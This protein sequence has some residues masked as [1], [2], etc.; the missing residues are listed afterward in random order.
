MEMLYAFTDESGA[1]GWDFDKKGVSTHFIITAIIIEKSKLD[2]LKNELEKIKSF[3]F[4]KGEMKSSTVGTNYK[5]RTKILTEILKLDFHIFPVIID[6][7]A[8]SYMKGLRF[9]TSFYKFM[10]NIVYKELKNG[11]ERL[12][13]VADEIGTDSY[14]D[15]FIKYIKEKQDIPNLFGEANFLFENSKNNIFIQLADFI[16]GTLSYCFDKNKITEETPNYYKI[17]QP[18]IIRLMQYPKNYN[19]YILDT[20]SITED[21]DYDV[22]NICFRQAKIFLKKYENTDDND[23]IAQKIVLEYLLFRFMNND[24]RGYIPTKEII[25]QLKFTKNGAFSISTFRLKIICKL[26]DAGVIIASSSK[27]Y[28]I[29]SKKSELYDFINHGVSVA[30]PVMERMKKCRDIIKFSTNGDIDLFNNTEY[31]SLYRFFDE[32]KNIIDDEK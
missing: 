24:K 8:C 12:T 11:F 14:M 1:F 16:S 23:I 25:N 3:Y 26:R 22:A 29:P 2:V 19:N 9:K 28:K 21:Y 13:V 18:K 27:G 4:Q 31:K 15:S 30:I 20:S 7:V 6:K 17:L 32:Y 10:N 5:R